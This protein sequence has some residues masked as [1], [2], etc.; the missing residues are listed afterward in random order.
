MQIFDSDTELRAIFTLTNEKIPE[1]FRSTFL[2]S[3]RTDHFHYPASQQAFNRIKTLASKRFHI[4]DFNSLVADPVIDEDLR[5]ALKTSRRKLKPLK[6]EKQISNNLDLLERYRKIR[7][8][9]EMSDEALSELQKPEVDV[10][11]LL[12]KMTDCV[13]RANA[14][15]LQ[16]EFFL[17]YGTNQSYES[18]VEEVLNGEQDVRIKTGYKAYDDKSGGV[19]ETGV[20]I[21]AGTTSGGK[22]TIAMNLGAYWYEHQQRSVC[23][24]SLEMGEKQETRRLMSHLTGIEFNKFKNGT[25]SDKE[26]KILRKRLKKFSDHGIKHEIVHTTISPKKTMDADSAFAMIKPY[27]FDIVMIDYIGLLDGQNANDQWFN[28]SEI[29]AISK[30]F[31]TANN[32]LVVI[33]AQLDDES[34]KLRYARGMK[35]H[36][37]VLWKWNYSKPEQRELRILPINV[38]KD[39]DSELFGFE[40][41]ERYDIMT[42]RDMDKE[43]GTGYGSGY[44]DDDE[45]DVP[46]KKKKKK[47]PSFSDDD[48]D[49]I[50]VSSKV[51]SKG[52]KSKSK[53]KNK[54]SVSSE[55]EDGY[56]VS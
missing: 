23:R 22:S 44:D 33:L 35:E 19:P 26:K 46:K 47:R 9:Y 15:V 49:A 21:L 1:D 52:K 37:D 36:A 45:D 7:A 43:S 28:L 10:D 56:I 25:L 50:E 17:T 4:I 41:A 20:F 39:R 11:F 13:T 16:D 30:R 38:D 14:S 42:A 8:I 27:Q 31:A 12:N 53:G 3:L 2:G 18:I 32:C 48:D 34:E 40:L 54:R 55:E 5:D 51:K 29:V 6:N 24:I